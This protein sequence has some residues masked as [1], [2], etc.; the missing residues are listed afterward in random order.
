LDDTFSTVWFRDMQGVLFEIRIDVN[1]FPIVTNNATIR[2][3]S[4]TLSRNQRRDKD[5]KEIMAQNLMGLSPAELFAYQVETNTHTN[6]LL[7]QPYFKQALDISERTV[8]E[9]LIKLLINTKQTRNAILAKPKIVTE[10]KSPFLKQKPFS[11]LQ[12]VFGPKSM[13]FGYESQSET[14]FRVKA[15]L[16]S[17]QP[18]NLREFCQAFCS[19]CSITYSFNE[20]N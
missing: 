11:N 2:L 7:F 4:V 16:V 1:K 15:M 6:V 5:R 3:R 19:H 13:V 17:C 9:E 20:V 18:Q 8:D 14:I 12:D 10:L